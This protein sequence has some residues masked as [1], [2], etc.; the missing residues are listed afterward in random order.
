L[1]RKCESKIDV[2]ASIEE[3]NLNSPEGFKN[4]FADSL[5]DTMT[6]PYGTFIIKVVLRER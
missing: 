1:S 6:Q 5:A 4:F 2:P 3:L